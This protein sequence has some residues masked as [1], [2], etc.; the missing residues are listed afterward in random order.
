MKSKQAGF[1]FGAAVLLIIFLA[2]CTS[3]MNRSLAVPGCP[4]GADCSGASLTL[5][6]AAVTPAFGDLGWGEVRGRVTDTSDG[7]AIAGATVTCTQRSNH[8]VS[9][10]SGSVKTAEDGSFVFPHIF[11]QETDQIQVTASEPRH[12]GD[13]LLQQ[14]F[15]HPGLYVNFSL[16]EIQL[17][18][19]PCCTAPACGENEVLSCRGVCPCGCGSTCVTKTSTP[20]NFPTQTPSMTATP[21]SYS[22]VDCLDPRNALRDFCPVAGNDETARSLLAP[23]GEILEGTLRGHSCLYVLQPVSNLSYL[24]YV[25]QASSTVSLI[26]IDPGLL[27]PAQTVTPAG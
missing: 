1:G 4:V 8:P 22:C 5:T 7:S 11:F 6:A 15:T 13:A 3:G 9:L 10:C 26:Y 2:G 17:T 18:M 21:V 23:Y 19:Q 14:H 24:Y 20:N 25:N 16:P 27:P 12:G